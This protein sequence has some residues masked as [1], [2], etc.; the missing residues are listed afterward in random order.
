MPS[1][2]VVH[3]IDRWEE[4]RSLPGFFK[5]L[6]ALCGA[7]LFKP[8][9]IFKQ[10]IVPCPAGFKNRLIRAIL[11][12]FILGYIKL[13]CDVANFLWLKH[14]APSVFSSFFQM[15]FSF[16]SS[17]VLSS[18]FFLLRPVISFVLTLGLTVVSVKIILGF[19]RPWKPALLVVCYKSAADIFYCIP[20]VGGLLAVVWSLALITVGIRE[21]Y[22]LNTFRSVMAAIIMPLMI[23]FF[24]ILS[25]GPSFNKVILRFYPETQSQ[26]LKLNDFTGY[27]YTTAIATAAKT[28]KQELGFYPAHLGVLKKYLSKN[29]TDDVESPDNSSG[30]VYAYKR[31]GDDHF[32][33]EAVPSKMKISGR[34]IF[35]SDETGQV[36]LYGPEGLWVRDSA[37][38]EKLIAADESMRG[39]GAR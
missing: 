17:A 39:A 30:Y 11:F 36:R 33:V 19:D 13:L 2:A 14:F 4:A 37:H 31:L 25:I 9:E 8:I 26:I 1:E 24:I 38:I 21:L 35:Y 18:P 27:L 10:L 6:A 29:I 16:L 32:S 34:F 5:A 22:K 12:A 3:P 28:Y 20:L 7:I 15:P 23:L